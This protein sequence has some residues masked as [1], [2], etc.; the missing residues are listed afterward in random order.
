MKKII[1]RILVLFGLPFVLAGIYYVL[2][3]SGMIFSFLMGK[4]GLPQ[5]DAFFPRA[6]IGVMGI[7]IIFVA[8]LV[9]WGIWGLTGI[10][11][12]WLNEWYMDFK[13]RY[14]RRQARI[15]Y[16]R[17]QEQLRREREEERAHSR[18]RR[19][20]QIMVNNEPRPDLRNRLRGFIHNREQDR[21]IATMS[22]EQ[23]DG[24]LSRYMDNRRNLREIRDYVQGI[25]RSEQFEL[26]EEDSETREI[27]EYLL[28]IGL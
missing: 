6:V 8:G 20:V 5:P 19:D 13:G 17:E 2:F 10:I 27:N 16:E 28:R 21:S 11:L 18:E 15:R 22:D 14:Q 25:L 12:N 1:L 26:D 24:Y 4:M 9:C 3:Y 7:V 23:F